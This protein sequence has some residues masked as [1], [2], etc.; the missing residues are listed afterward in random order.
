MTSTFTEDELSSLYSAAHQCYVTGDFKKAC[1]LFTVLAKAAPFESHYWRGL[2]SSQQM[3]KNYRAALH[4]WSVAAILHEHDP[5]IHFHAA[6]CLIS[7]GETREAAKAL[8]MAESQCLQND[9]EL[10]EKIALL[11]TLYAY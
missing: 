5:W 7:E 11:K 10:R 9:A 8:D 6:E 3:Q 1:D 2:A 4:A